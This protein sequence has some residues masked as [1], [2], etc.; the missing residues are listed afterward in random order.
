MN[1][2]ILVG[3]L[4]FYSKKMLCR[5]Y[6]PI[7]DGLYEQL[8][9]YNYSWIEIDESRDLSLRR[10]RYDYPPGHTE[11]WRHRVFPRAA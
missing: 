10:P 7:F 11:L 9:L 1:Y 4:A 6:A 8:F 3:I 5:R 2:E